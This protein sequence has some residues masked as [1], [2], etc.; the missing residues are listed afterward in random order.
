VRRAARTRNGDRAT[1]I[2]DDGFCPFQSPVPFVLVRHGVLSDWEF[3]VDRR[4]G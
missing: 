4:T 1:A 2:H 3:L